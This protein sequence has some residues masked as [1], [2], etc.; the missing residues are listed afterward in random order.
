MLPLKNIRKIHAAGQP[1]VLTE[2]EFD[3]S[4]RILVLAP[5]PD[6]F[7]E[8]AVTLKFFFD[9][10]HEIYLVVLTGAS[11]G[12]LD[13]FITPSTQERK[14]DVREEEQINALKFFG[15]PLSNVRFL[16]LPEDGAGELILNQHSRAIIAQ[17][18]SEQNP[19][20]VSL[21]YGND[22]N[23]SHQR[24]FELFRDLARDAAKPILGLY[25]RDPKTIDIRIDAYVPFSEA[26]AKWKGEMLRFHQSQHTRN[27][28][29]RN[30]GIDDRILQLNQDVAKRLGIALSYAEGFQLELF[31]V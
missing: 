11:S 12:V 22:T 29:T 2:L 26:T 31:N 23:I 4:S 14:E 27:L 21:P 25:H 28:Q 9:A 13:S 6:D 10:G 18:F 19:D 30:Y 24:T 3:R 20:I 7:D 16:R 5:H 15:F 8:V 17:I 1:G